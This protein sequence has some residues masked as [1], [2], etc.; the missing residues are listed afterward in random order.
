MEAAVVRSK[1][2][3]Q[4]QPTQEEPKSG[5]KQK[6]T[7]HT[8]SHSYILQSETNIPNGPR[9]QQSNPIGR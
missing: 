7:H 5:A 9:G 1:G 8:H 2:E 4:Q 3:G 6:H